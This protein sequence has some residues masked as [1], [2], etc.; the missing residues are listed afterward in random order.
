MSNISGPE[1]TSGAE[2]ASG[3]TKTA[4]AA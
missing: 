1:A 3:C 4:S 2:A